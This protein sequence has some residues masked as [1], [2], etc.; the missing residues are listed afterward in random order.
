[1]RGELCKTCVFSGIISG[2]KLQEPHC[3]YS[4]T[5]RTCL[6]RT[7]DGIID[8]RGEDKTK[9]NLYVKGNRK[10]KKRGIVLL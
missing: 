10:E 6:K 4:A 2:I 5:G 8:I 9:C 1:M 3:N 7:S